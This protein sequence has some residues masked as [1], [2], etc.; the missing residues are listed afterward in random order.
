MFTAR[1]RTAWGLDVGRQNMRLIGIAEMAGAA[2]LVLPGV[3][4]VAPWI[5]A[6]AAAGLSVLM[7]AATIFHVRRSEPIALNL[8]LAALALVVLVGRALVEPV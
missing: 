6:V 4:G 1:P 2:G 7:I 5:T 8:V 3:T